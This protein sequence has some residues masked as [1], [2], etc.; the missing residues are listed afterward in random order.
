MTIHR[1]FLTFNH[2]HPLSSAGLSLLVALHPSTYP[3]GLWPN[4]PQLCSR[5]L[6]NPSSSPLCR[7]RFGIM[8]PARLWDC[9]PQPG[10]MGPLPPLHGPGSGD[11][12][13]YR[14]VSWCKTPPSSCEEH[15]GFALASP[16]PLPLP[17]V[18]PGTLHL[19]TPP[20]HS[21]TL[22]DPPEPQGL[23]RAENGATI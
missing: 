21:G 14:R 8:Q 17:T 20:F 15:L 12:R 13:S 1:S 22:P 23:P 5:P 9:A 11:S 3:R 16:F 4:Q 2:H 7:P 19:A 10:C 18:T 6:A